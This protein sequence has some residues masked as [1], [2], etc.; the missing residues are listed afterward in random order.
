MQYDEWGGTVSVASRMES[1]GAQGR[2]HVSEAFTMNLNSNQGSRNAQSN[3][4]I[5]KYQNLERGSID[6]KERGADRTCWLESA[7]A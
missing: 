3:Q 4:E 1:A 5:M 2:V 7:S 6:I